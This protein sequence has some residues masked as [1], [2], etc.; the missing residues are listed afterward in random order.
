MALLHD[1]GKLA[2]SSR[3]LDKPSELTAAEFARVKEHPLF[4]RW[5]LERVSCFEALAPLAAAHHERLDGSGYP[6]GLRADD[7]TL[8]MRVLAVADVYEALTASRPYRPALEED[9]ALATIRRDVPQR[10]D[11]DAY[12]ALET[13]ID[14]PPVA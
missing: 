1:I 5:V 8:A 7:L 4:T 9:E 6:S 14:L 12:E 10:L 3:I 11:P 13:V 2:V